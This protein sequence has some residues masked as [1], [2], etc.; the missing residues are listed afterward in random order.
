M[1][2][3]EGQ[4][5]YIEINGNKVAKSTEYGWEAIAPGWKVE[6]DYLGAITI[7]SNGVSVH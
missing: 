6:D 4:D 1:R 2:V 7:T 3:Q 5:L